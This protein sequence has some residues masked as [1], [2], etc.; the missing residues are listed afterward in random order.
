MRYGY[1]NGLVTIEQYNNMIEKYKEIDYQINRIK[2][3]VITVDERI[4]GILQSADNTIQAKGKLKAENI[5]KRP[6]ITI[7]HILN[8]FDEDYNELISPIIEM[9][10]KY[11]GYITRDME[12]IKKLDKL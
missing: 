8:I 10:I 7:K 5:L 6:G 2:D 12:K 11:E 3:T 1:E 9:E 4:K